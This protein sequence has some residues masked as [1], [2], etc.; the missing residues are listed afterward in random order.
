MALSTLSSSLLLH[1]IARDQFGH[2]AD[3]VAKH[4]NTVWPRRENVHI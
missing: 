3:A 2:Q 4:V 1:L